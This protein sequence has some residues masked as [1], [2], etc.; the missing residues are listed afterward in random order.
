MTSIFFQK[1]HTRKPLSR[2]YIDANLYTN[3]EDIY[4]N[5]PDYFSLIPPKKRSKPLYKPSSLSSVYNLR[6]RT[7]K[8]PPSPKPYNPSYVPEYITEI[9]SYYLKIDED[10][11]PLFGYMDKQT[12]I[13]MKMRAILIDWLVDVHLKFK[14]TPET[15][16]ITVNLIDKYLSLSTI[17]RVK[18][19]LL[20]ITCLFIS[21]KYEEIYPPEL[22]DHVYI[23]DQ[24]YS[25]EE[26]IKM[27]DDILRKLNFELTFPTSLRYLEIFTE[28][29]KEKENSKEDN[30]DNNPNNNDVFLFS[31][32][33]LELCLVE[34][35]ML[36]Y[37]NGEIALSAYYISYKIKNEIINGCSLERIAKVFDYDKGRIKDCSKDIC[38][39]LDNSESYWLQAVKKKFS[40]EQ[41]MNVANW[42]K[43]LYF[44]SN[45]K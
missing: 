4:S 13:N 37:T 42:K 33:L 19:Q 32:Y 16:Y 21:C 39:I 24:T 43:Y 14:L 12:E 27:E 29:M 30:K 31:R 11:K 22:K 26:I 9:L 2:I 36:K 1:P 40:S 5:I 6:S 35:A 10:T 18:L 41:Y 34:Y 45:T 8:E 38:T 15:L 17:P 20:G 23:T 7:I 25:K 44:K 3:P 28:I